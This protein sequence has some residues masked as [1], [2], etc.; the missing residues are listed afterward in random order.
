MAASKPSIKW[1]NPIFEED[2]YWLPSIPHSGTLPIGNP[3]TLNLK[4][5]NIS[6]WIQ[7]GQKYYLI[8]GSYGFVSGE[9]FSFLGLF[10][11]SFFIRLLATLFP[12]EVFGLGGSQ[13]SL[14]PGD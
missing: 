11:G 8:L 13:L 14:S 9:T 2:A 1:P 3:L 10:Y 6:R 5:A 4:V 12:I 7:R